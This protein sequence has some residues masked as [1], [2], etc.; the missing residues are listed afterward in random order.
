MSSPE[1]ASIEDLARRLRECAESLTSSAEKLKLAE[2]RQ[3]EYI[4]KL[5]ELNRQIKKTI[6]E[7]RKASEACRKNGERPA[8]QKPILP[9]GAEAQSQ[10]RTPNGS[11]FKF[12]DLA[13]LLSEKDRD[14]RKYLQGSPEMTYVDTMEFSSYAEYLRFKNQPAISDSDIRKSNIDEL[15]WRLIS[16]DPG[17]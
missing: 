13:Q 2:G 6:M 14:M 4:K 1:K 11:A 8:E 9:R 17:S 16:P 10:N 7:M 3:K 5:N 15:L 12:L